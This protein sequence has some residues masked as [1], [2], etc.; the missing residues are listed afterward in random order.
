MNKD[1]SS[2]TRLLLPLLR[3]RTMWPVRRRK[4]GILSGYFHDL[5]SIFQ[6]YA[7]ADIWLF[8]FSDIP[9]NGGW[10]A[11]HFLLRSSWIRE[12]PGSTWLKHNKCVN[13]RQ[14]TSSCRN[15]DLRQVFIACSLKRSASISQT[16]LIN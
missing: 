1:I 9:Y 10:S 2:R 6:C 5:V 3:W 13:G 14:S 7:L 15:M 12:E 4:V 16:I 11:F 8:I